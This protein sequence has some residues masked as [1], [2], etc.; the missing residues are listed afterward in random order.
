MDPPDSSTSSS[1]HS[2]PFHFAEL[3]GATF[4]G[5]ES[6][7]QPQR[8]SKHEKTPQYPSH[9]MFWGGEHPPQSQ[10]AH[11]KAAFPYAQGK[12]TMTNNSPGEHTI[13]EALWDIESPSQAQRLAQHQQTQSL[14]P[15]STAY[16]SW[17]A[18][19]TV[20]EHAG[21]KCGL[22]WEPEASPMAMHA[23]MINV[24][25][26]TAVQEAQHQE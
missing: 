2:N 6:P 10:H 7:P 15:Q 23:E 8:P 25:D 21:T 18:K 3:Y 11:G 26:E 1:T 13:A 12:A 5:G 24:D 22:C 20:N 19:L 14:P 17:L 9:E 16:A 4:W